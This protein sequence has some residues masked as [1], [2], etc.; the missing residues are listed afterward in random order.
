MKIKTIGYINIISKRSSEIEV[1]KKT[2]KVKMYKTLKSLRFAQAKRYLSQKAKYVK[3]SYQAFLQS[4]FLESTVDRA[5]KHLS[6]IRKMGISTSE[7]FSAYVDYIKS[8]TNLNNY[9]YSLPKQIRLNL[10]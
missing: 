4:S 6:D 1:T 2:I 9:K 7:S 10:F 5:K 3:I 8:I